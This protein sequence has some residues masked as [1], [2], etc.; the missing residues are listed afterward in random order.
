MGGNTMTHGRMISA[1]ALISL[2]LGLVPVAMAGPATDRL[3]PEIDRVIATL[4]NPAL[5]GESKTAERR[6]AIRDITDEVF[7]WTEMARRALGRHWAG[8]TSAEQ[9]EFV[10]LFRDLIERA[11]VSKIER[12]TGEPIA[13]VGES[14]DA[15][16]ATVRTRITTKQNQEVPI[17][18]RLGRQGDRWLVYDVLIEN[19]SLIGNYR[20]QFDGIIKTSSYEELV[21]RMKSPRSS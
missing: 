19:I 7:D 6:K 9:Q 12:Y 21:K 1:T 15:D 11:Y 2:V 5:K 20:T 3:K 8:R 18:Y 16:Q 10:G 14:I 4:D 13:F 17:D